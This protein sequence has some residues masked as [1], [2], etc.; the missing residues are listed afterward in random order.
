MLVDSNVVVRIT[1]ESAS[2]PSAT[3]ARRMI[4]GSSMSRRSRNPALP[5]SSSAPIMFASCQRATIH[6]LRN[7]VSFRSACLR[8]LRNVP[9]GRVPGCIET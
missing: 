1:P 9:V 3:A 2:G 5:K 7:S 8:I 4:W 6:S